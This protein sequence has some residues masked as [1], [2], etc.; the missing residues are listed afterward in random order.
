MKVA[1]CFL[2]SK[3]FRC[4]HRVRARENRHHSTHKDGEAV[5]V[6]TRE[7]AARAHNW[8]TMRPGFVDGVLRC[9]RLMSNGVQT[10]GRVVCRE[11]V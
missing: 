9:Y 2:A 11:V 3:W 5:R 4:N 10:V 7:V 8:V 6:G 1:H